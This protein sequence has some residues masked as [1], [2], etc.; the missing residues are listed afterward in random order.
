MV[1]IKNFNER[2]FWSKMKRY[3]A[4][5]GK[6]LAEPAFSMFYCMKDK[7]TPIQAKAT[8]IGALAYF[9]LPTDAISDF[10]PFIGFTD[11]LTVIITTLKLIK[12]YVKTS[13]IQKAREQSIILLK[14][15]VVD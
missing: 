3:A 2:S 8:I 6:K 4:V 10:L 13:H 11:D 9:I 1:R 5:A 12:K 14:P 15:I 7:D